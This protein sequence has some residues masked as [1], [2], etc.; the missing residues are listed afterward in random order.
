[1]K[2]LQ[3]WLYLA[4]YLFSKAIL[5]RF[6]DL[7]LAIYCILAALLAKYIFSYLAILV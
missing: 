1:V 2:Y 3:G 4:I 6:K 5:A 7:Y